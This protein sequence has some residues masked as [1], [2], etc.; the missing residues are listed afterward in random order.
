MSGELNPNKV[1]PKLQNKNQAQINQKKK[2]IVNKTE[3]DQH[4]DLLDERKPNELR[5]QPM[6]TLALH[7]N[8]RPQRLTTNQPIPWNKTVVWSPVSRCN[9]NTASQCSTEPS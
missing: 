9:N 5:I 4:N 3:S 1:S 8:G 2:K 6:G 7:L